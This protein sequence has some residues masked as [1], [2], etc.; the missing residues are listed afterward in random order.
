LPVGFAGKRGG[1]L[2]AD[3]LDERGELGGVVGKEAEKNFAVD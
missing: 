1:V 3:V 2:M